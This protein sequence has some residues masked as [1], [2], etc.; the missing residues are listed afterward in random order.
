MYEIN[1]RVEIYNHSEPAC[2][3]QLGV[4]EAIQLAYDGYTRYYSVRLE[5]SHMLCS[6]ID[7]ELMEG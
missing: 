3:G 2:N 7:D 1:S 6:C 4:I 5:D